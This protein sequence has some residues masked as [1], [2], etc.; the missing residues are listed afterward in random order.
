MDSTI[1]I[2][3]GLIATFIIGLVRLF[4]HGRKLGK[5]VAFVAKYC[6]KF[7]D[8]ATKK[9]FD[10]EIYIWLTRKV[11]A[12]QTEL[13]PF[14]VVDYG[15]PAAGYMVRNY[16]AIANL[17]PEIRRQKTRRSLS[18]PGETCQE[19][20]AICLDVLTRYVGFL[21]DSIE[22]SVNEMMNPFI[23]LREGV[24]FILFLP[25]SL[26]H[27]IGLIRPHTIGKIVGSTVAKVFSGL[28]AFL[29]LLG[30]II[31]IVVSWDAFIKIVTD[32]WQRIF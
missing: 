13:G 9:E 20:V 26:L 18:G 12:I 11:H 5:R 24:R 10:G 32:L 29:G 16:Q 14:G 22:E 30:V 23:W 15:P 3:V 8:F 4:L 2:L 28:V 7:A 25:V 17:L 1:I 6:T 21:E 31:K 27:W 19:Q